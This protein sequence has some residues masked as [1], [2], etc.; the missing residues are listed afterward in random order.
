MGLKRLEDSLATLGIAVDLLEESATQVLSAPR[1]R[2]QGG[3]APRADDVGLL[4]SPDQLTSVKQ[5]LDDA[6]ERLESA[7]ETADGAR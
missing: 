5:R 4:F 2:R 6:I 7:L 3:R 1:S